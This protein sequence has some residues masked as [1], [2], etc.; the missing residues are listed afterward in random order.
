LIPHRDPTILL[1]TAG[2]VQMK[3]YF[4]GL[5]NPP[6]QRLASC[7]KCF[8]ATDIDSVGDSKHLTFFEMLG[9][10]SVGDYFKREAI[11]WAWEF[12][13]KHLKLPT[14]R[15]WITIYFDDDE[16]FNY[17]REIGIPAEK[18]LRFGEEDNFWGP[19]GDS[20]PCGPCSEIHYDMG[21]EFGCG[22]P[23]CKP[24]CECSRVSEIWNLVFT[25]YN[26]DSDGHCAPLAKPNIDTGMGLERTL[27]AIQGKPSPYE[28]D[29]FY[30]LI[31]RVCHLAG[32]EYGQDE[33]TDRAI[34]IVA[35]H[36]RG[37]PF[38][39]ADGVMP[40]N[41]ERGYVLRRILRRAS[42]FGRRLGL[43]KPFLGEIAELVVNKMGHTY[44]ELVAN[45]GLIKQ[46]VEAEEERFISTLDVGLNSINATLEK[47]SKRLQK[48]ASSPAF[49]QMQE[50]LQQLAEQLG[51]VTQPIQENLQQ[52]AEQLRSTTQPIQ[53]NLQQLTEQ[54]G[55][56][57]QPNP[58]IRLSPAYQQMQERLQQ[59]QE[60]VTLPGKEV[61]KLHDTFGF[62][63]ELTAEI[64]GEKGLSIDWEGFE[65]EM[66]R[67]RE[68]A[69]AHM[70]GKGE[71]KVKATGILK[72][73]DFVGYKMTTSQ[74]KVLEL[75]VKGQPL[76]TAS[77][78]EEVDIILDKTPFYGEMGGQVGD[79][80]EIRGE[81]G[82]MTITNTVK[83]IVNGSELVVHQGEVVEGSISV[84]EEVEA[85]VDT[86]H[87]LDIAR[88]HT[89]THLLQAAMREILGS[90][91]QQ[92]GS[93]V[94]PERFRFDFPQLLPP[95]QKE[96]GEIQQWVNERIRQNLVVKTMTVPYDEAIA[97]GAIALFEEKYGDTVRVVAIDEPAISKELCGG[98]HVKSTGEIGT[99]LITSEGSIGTGLRRI[100]AITGRAAESLINARFS[101][102]QNMADAV[103]SPLEKVPEKVKAL[104]EYLE[105]ER[106]RSLSLERELSRR[107]VET[108]L[109]QAERVN[110]VTVLAARVPSLTM[111]ILREMGDILRDR[112][113][114]G[115]IVLATVYDNKPNFLA[116]VTSDLIARGFNAADIVKQVAGV[117]GGGGGG[118]ADMAQAGGKDP[119]KLD[120]ALR[121]V[122]NIITK[123]SPSS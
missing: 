63:K 110:G 41:E 28:T 67:Q 45:Q 58:A 57:T 120:E 40:S 46:M 109:Q 117:T 61:F 39:I 23:D 94:E 51:N 53:E 38:L 99:F 59:I 60:Y 104:V 20:G 78:G 123:Q 105:K 2:M 22:K 11:S 82:R 7:Q 112:L 36:G 33:N 115:V 48:F 122:K 95:S 52:L 72:Q 37:I 83:H 8:R 73:T 111:P 5:E 17:W 62:P 84:D 25:Q 76:R 121:L 68:M 75:S 34:R 16:A 50:I 86:T 44:P 9:N 55:M 35:E 18:I 32:K 70:K 10:F 14:E 81:R 47:T 1:T 106:K 66:E 114:S 15:L 91:I 100:E 64:A 92:R 3:P 101:S 85:R 119:S 21:E 118:K 80:G 30:P 42:V 69:R 103:E 4:L 29:L 107:V 98:T 89:A 116:M 90:H 71:L 49:R 65:N 113:K 26:Q 93:L 96:I 77:Q 74:A 108:L 56:A 24:N 97:E 19:V 43:D 88:N 102:L 79:T 13:T 12:V 31:D 27:A 87:R 6:S 54:L